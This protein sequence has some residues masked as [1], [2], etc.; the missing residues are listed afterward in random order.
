MTQPDDEERERA[1]E[2]LTM[3]YPVTLE[4]LPDA[5]LDEDPPDRRD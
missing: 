3:N 2:R 1:A 5:L 4:R